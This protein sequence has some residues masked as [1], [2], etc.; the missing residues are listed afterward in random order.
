MDA[1]LLLPLAAALLLTLAPHAAADALPTSGDGS[2]LEDHDNDGN[3]E[4][5]KIC[6]WGF[7]DECVLQAYECFQPY[8]PHFG[9]TCP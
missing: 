2:P 1:R 3:M 9:I 4:I 8:R 6:V 5:G 7:P